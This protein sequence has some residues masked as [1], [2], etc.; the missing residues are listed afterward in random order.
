[1]SANF[2]DAVQ[3]QRRALYSD[4]TDTQLIMLALSKLLIDNAAALAVE[5]YERGSIRPDEDLQRRVGQL[6]EQVRK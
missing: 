5:L 4:K 1:M 6:E 2:E 3:R